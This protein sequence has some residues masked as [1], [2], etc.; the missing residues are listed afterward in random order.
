MKPFGA[1]EGHY[2][3]ANGHMSI[4]NEEPKIRTVERRGVGGVG[5]GGERR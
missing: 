4:K 1:K 2:V 5:G 3:V